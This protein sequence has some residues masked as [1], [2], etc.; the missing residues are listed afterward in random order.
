MEP[1]NQRLPMEP[2]GPRLDIPSTMPADLQR[3]NPFGVAVARREEMARLILGPPDPS[4][5]ALHFDLYQSL[6]YAV[7]HSRTYMDN[8]ETL[9]IAALNVTLQR[10]LFDPSPF[11]TQAFNF[12]G[13][14]RDLD[15]QSAVSA[16][17]TV[18][19]TQQLPYGG[20]IT[21]QGLLTFVDALNQHTQAGETAQLALT[22]SIPLLRGG[23]DQ[24]RAP[25]IVGTAIDLCRAEFRIFPPRFRRADRHRL[26]WRAHRRRPLTI[27]AG[28]TSNPPIL[29][30]DAG[31]LRQGE[32]QL[33]R[34][35]A[36]HRAAALR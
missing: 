24:S 6:A 35:A 20:T 18:G 15:Y 21:A 34:S 29:P 27:T 7:Q 10:H 2:L 13:T 32:N 22:G 8:A 19:V 3:N 28:V 30:T 5:R 33:H 1:V 17:T 23:D 26:F 12:N 9:Y 4:V 31:A 25:D 11:A 36:S 16:V 14:Q